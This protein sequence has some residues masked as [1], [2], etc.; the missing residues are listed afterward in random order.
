M[1]QSTKKLIRQQSIGI[2]GLRKRVFIL[3]LFL[4]AYL[5]YMHRDSFT[6]DELDHAEAMSV[7]HVDDHI[8]H[9]TERDTHISSDDNRLPALPAG[10]Y[11][12]DKGRPETGVRVTNVVLYKPLDQ[13]K[14]YQH[15]FMHKDRL[16]RQGMRATQI[17]PND[18]TIVHNTRF[19]GKIITGEMQCDVPCLWVNSAEK[20]HAS[21]INLVGSSSPTTALKK[22]LK[23]SPQVWNIAFSMEGEHKYATMSNLSAFDA[24][25]TYRWASEIK[26]SYFEFKEYDI[27]KPAVDFDSAIKEVTFLARNCQ[28][29]RTAML[30]VIEPYIHIAAIGSCRSN[31]EWDKNIP[32]SDKKAMLRKYLFHFAWENGVVDDYVTEKVYHAL[33]SGT[34]P[35]YH[36]AKNIDS[37]V[38]EG[39][40]IKM[41]DFASLDELG[42]YLN[43]L[44]HD[45]EAYMKYHEWRSKPVLVEKL[46]KRF[47]WSYDTTEC[48]V[49]RWTYAQRYGLDWN[50]DT[51]TFS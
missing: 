22:N 34:L 11:E 32:R 28:E 48:R 18:T 42:E 27:F 7:T 6:V 29:D 30:D 21:V 51:Q 38:P 41:T 35:V 33:A 26:K 23:T 36:G 44:A 15:A 45:K 25:M 13:T 49:C 39:S 14:E 19:G 4:V 24:E 31:T 43:I 47:A 50:A 8:N 3:F 9:H 40:I 20:A 46:R 2:R 16:P 1:T 10:R 37:Y 5:I 12:E 17:N